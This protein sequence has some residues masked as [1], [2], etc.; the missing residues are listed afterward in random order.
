[1]MVSP[2]TTNSRK[3]LSERIGRLSQIGGITPFIHAAG[4]AKGA[5]TLRVRTAQGLELWVVPDNGLDIF[6]A[7]Y[8]GKSL[9]WHSPTGVVHPAYYSG[10]GLEWLRSFAGGLVCTCGLSTAGAPSE[11]AGE[12][13]GLHGSIANTP[14]EN[15]TWAEEWQGDDC[16]LTVAGSVRET[17]V[18][19]PNLLL[20]RTITTSLQRASFA[21][22]DV[23]EN[24]GPKESPL[25]VL[26]HLNFGYPL[27]TERS[28]I[29]SSSTLAEPSDE[30]AAQSKDNWD[31]FEAPSQGIEE[32]V[33]FHT[34][35]P[36]SSGMVTIVLVSD[37]SKRDFGI[38]LRY[39]KT[40]LT[41][42]TEWKMTGNNHFVLGLEPGNCRTKG[43]AAERKRGALKTL[44]PGERREFRFEIAVLDSEAQVAEAIRSIPKREGI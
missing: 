1:M 34:M 14:A 39:D 27:L 20:R 36:D 2:D 28:K 25:M 43:R 6:E 15:V 10:R 38:S 7:T 30:F 16:L 31:I 41:E 22:H 40:T 37:D 12:S 23:V 8:L 24:Q 3:F 19:G 11:D 13:L 44:T 26:Y 9:C 32:R 29:Y 4:K 33:Y 17:S 42:F 18:F 35:E 5:S 21:I